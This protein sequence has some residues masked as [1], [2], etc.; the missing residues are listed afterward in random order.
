MASERPLSL[1][2]R[3]DRAV[4]RLDS[5]HRQLKEALKDLDPEEAFLGSRWS[6]WE[7]IQHLDAAKYVD[8][9]EK[10]ASGEME[11][12]PPFTSR[13]EH[14]Q[15]DL[16]HLDETY[17]RFRSLITGLSE[18]QLTKPATPA[19][20]H[21]SYPGLTLLELIERS[22]GHAATHSQQ[23]E[24]TR[25]YVA[26]FSS[27]ERAVTVVGLGPGDPAFVSPRVKELLAFAD[28]TAGS[29]PALAVVRPWIRGTE[30][31]IHPGNMEEVLSRLGREARSG[32]WSLVCCLGDPAE[33][34]PNLL[35]L[36]RKHCDH[37]AV[38]P[39]I[40]TYQLALAAS[41]LSP[42]ECLVMSLDAA[43]SSA[44]RDE[45]VANL[46]DSVRHI[47]V[48][49]DDNPA[50]WPPLAQELLAGGIDPDRGVTVLSALR[51]GGGHRAD[52]TVG[53]LARQEKP[54]PL[55]SALLFPPSQA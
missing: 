39:G 22:S 47:V 19:N 17:S 49:G 40:G 25:K 52:T 35:A 9:L 5:G 26:A 1:L 37:V 38:H 13:A 50:A 10:I 31:V 36:A 14:L 21:N 34:S 18:E 42:Q 44:C 2:E 51:V 41:G 48:L 23:V 46:G 24:A 3:R 55:P 27:K 53:V 11:T 12:L 6:V 32:I 20:P 33:S 29:E 54:Q 4:E 45:L 15:Q 16:D 8:A 30:T 43:A 28:Y 7:V